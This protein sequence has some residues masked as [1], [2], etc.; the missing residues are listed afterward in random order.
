MTRAESVHPVWN[1]LL[2]NQVSGISV[3]N[4]LPTLYQ[5]P[6]HRDRSH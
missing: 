4:V 6:A 1:D 3:R 2:R 5:I